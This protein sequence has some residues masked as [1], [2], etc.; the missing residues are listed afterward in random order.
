MPDLALVDD[1]PTVRMALQMLMQARRPHWRVTPLDGFSSLCEYLSDGGACD[2]VL[3]DL[4]L[5]GVQGFAALAHLRVYFPR[6][7]LVV[8][9][10]HEDEQLA[11]RA[12][13]LGARAFL[14]KVLA[15]DEVCEKVDQ[16]LADDMPQDAPDADMSALQYRLLMALGL[17]L[18]GEDLS[19]AMQQS[20]EECAAL[21]GELM[22]QLELSE[23]SELLAHA[24]ALLQLD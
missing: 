9:T 21:Q 16:V 20:A 14:P 2:L 12:C 13:R 7:P 11:R 5:P 6:L 3:L 8:L 1:Q 15:V 4:G 19:A 10:G 24:Q 18:S 23:R 22:L 17:G